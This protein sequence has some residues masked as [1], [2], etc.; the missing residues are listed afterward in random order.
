[1]SLMRND[2]DTIKDDERFMRMALKEAEAAYAAG[3]VP[4]GAVIVCEGR[5]ISRAHNMT[6]TLND[7]TAHAEMQVIT[8]AANYLGGKYLN[9]CTLYVT[10]EPC[11][12]CAGAIGWAQISR[13]IYGAPDEKRGYRLYAPRVMHPRSEAVG[14]VLEDESRTL[15]LRFFR[16]RRT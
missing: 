5:V 7:V 16:E 2:T 4:I 12:M 1:M 15:M 11:P 6:E 10:V 3:E 14:G 8:A 9:G 13:I